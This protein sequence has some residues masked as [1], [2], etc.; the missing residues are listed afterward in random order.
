[1][2]IADNIV[3]LEIIEH[4]RMFDGKSIQ[5]PNALHIS[6]N[7][8]SDPINERNDTEKETACVLGILRFFICSS[9]DKLRLPS[10]NCSSM[11]DYYSHTQRS[12]PQP[13]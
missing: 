8:A 12:T 13:K 2:I 4:L 5:P 7:D 6:T 1:M 3:Y 11:V 9:C 10:T